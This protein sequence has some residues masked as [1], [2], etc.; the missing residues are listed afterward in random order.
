MLY[1][2]KISPPI[3]W[4]VFHRRH[5]PG[6]RWL[7][8][9][10]TPPGVGCNPAGQSVKLNAAFGQAFEGAEQGEATRDLT[11]AVSLILNSKQGRIYGFVDPPDQPVSSV[12]GCLQSK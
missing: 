12:E 8:R 6:W 10:R 2:V 5:M 7:C 3:G 9:R 11:T 4:R 1:A